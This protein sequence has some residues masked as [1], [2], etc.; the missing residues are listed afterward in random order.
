M[1]S[2]MLLIKNVEGAALCFEHAVTRMFTFYALILKIGPV[3]TS[4]CLK[5][6]S[7]YFPLFE[8]VSNMMI[9]TSSCLK[10]AESY[11]N[12]LPLKTP[13]QAAFGIAHTQI[14]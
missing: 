4:F 3:I 12:Y 7:H 13:E 10:G 5:M 11:C 2:N 6:L 9:I 1:F 8:A 14:I